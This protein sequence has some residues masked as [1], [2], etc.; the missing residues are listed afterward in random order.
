MTY[1]DTIPTTPKE[2]STSMGVNAPT[3][4][5]SKLSPAVKLFAVILLGGGAALFALSGSASSSEPVA[6]AN[7]RVSSLDIE[8][9]SK[10]ASA[11]T[12]DE[13]FASNCNHKVAPF[14]CLRNNGGPHGGCS[15]T[16]WIAG[17]CDKQCD[18][19]GCSD[20]DIPDDA[21]NCDTTC[22]KKFCADSSRLCGSDVPYQCTGGA[23]TYGCSS[24]MLLWTLRTSS[25]AC[26]SCCNIETCE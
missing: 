25:T 23:S 14:T 19:S 24:D 9:S 1:Y 5:R 3:T 12:F 11:C 4:S 17:T 16:P 20:L 2:Q 22:T 7:I 26:S 6:N 8:G 21:E 18:L 13:C 10:G 15:A